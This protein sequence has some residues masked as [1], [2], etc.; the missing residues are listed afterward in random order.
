MRAGTRNKDSDVF[1]DLVWRQLL[2]FFQFF[3]VGQVLDM[4]ACRQESHD[5]VVEEAGG[6][7]SQ[8][9]PNQL[10]YRKMGTQHPSFHEVLK[11]M[12]LVNFRFLQVLS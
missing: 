8:W 10:S 9:G 3:F 2:A 7:I 12:T 6:S 11:F 4:S 5:H 1:L